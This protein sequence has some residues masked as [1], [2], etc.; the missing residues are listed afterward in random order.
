MGDGIMAIANAPYKTADFEKVAFETGLQI[1][2]ETAR[3]QRTFRELWH[4]DFAV[5]A[6]ISSGF[7]SVGFFPNTD[8]GVYTAIGEPVNLAARLCSAAQPNSVATTKAVISASKDASKKFRVKRGGSISQLKGFAANDLEFYLASPEIVQMQVE[9]KQRCP[10]C[11]HGLI[12]G[13]DLGD[14][15][16]VQCENCQYSDIQEK[17]ALPVPLLKAG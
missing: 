2:E 16:M 7:V 6:G 11:A 4:A 13:A 1:I 8:F 17:V 12:L 14:C 5:R 10:L 3:R 9:E 15:I